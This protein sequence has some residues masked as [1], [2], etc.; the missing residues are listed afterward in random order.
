MFSARVSQLTESPTIGVLE[1]TRR[2]RQQG[3]DIVDFGVGE[4]DFATPRHIQEAGARAILAG[5]THYVPSRGIPAL[6][7]AIARKLETDN[8][9]RY[10]PDREII[11]TGSSKLALVIA[12]LT[13]LQAGD[14]ALLL[15]PAWVSYDPIVRLAD[16]TP[17]HIPLSG[18]EHFRISEAVLERWLTPRTKLLILNTPNNPTGRVASDEELAAIAAVAQRH[19]LLAITDEIYEKIVFAGW[20]HRSLASLPGMRERSIVVNGFSKGYAMTGWR[21]G[22]LACDAALSAEMLKVQQHVVGCAASFVQ[23][24]AVQALLGPQEPVEAMRQ[25]YQARRDLVVQGLNSLPGVR[26]SAPQGTFYAFPD[27]SGCGFASG[28]AGAEYLL[29]RAH[30]ALTPGEA[31]GAAGQGHVRL[32]FATSREAIERGIAR[33]DEALRAV[34]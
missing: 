13:V 4:P 25:E 22:Y 31:F 19:N 6:R 27:V 14:E 26:C 29:D 8:G 34:V 24:A 16:A 3:V 17:V 15:D 11:V 5:D 28:A 32:S 1:R 10:D 12:V 21:L 18:E 33:L 7:E 2:L 20:A 9:L 23:T 30:V